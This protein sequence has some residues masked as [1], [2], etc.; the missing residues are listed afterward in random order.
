MILVKEHKSTRGF[1]AYCLGSRQGL[2]R[3]G[4]RVVPF[5]PFWV[6]VSLLAPSSTLIM[7]GSLRNLVRAL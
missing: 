6:E 4:S 5:C 1:R 2:F 7:K 3:L